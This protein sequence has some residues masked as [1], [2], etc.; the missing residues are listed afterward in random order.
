MAKK[1]P[2]WSSPPWLSHMEN[3]AVR[4]LAFTA[5]VVFF[6]S[7]GKRGLWP[8]GPAAPWPV[9]VGSGDTKCKMCE[10]TRAGNHSNYKF[11]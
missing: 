7:R 5:A 9:Q 10:K 11:N 3:E 4:V 1:N 8:I 6:F 2:T